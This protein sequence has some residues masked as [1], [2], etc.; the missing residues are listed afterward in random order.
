[1]FRAAREAARKEGDG[2]GK[3]QHDKA[4]VFPGGKVVWRLR[5]PGFERK[6]P[7]HH[8][9][10]PVG[11]GGT[12]HRVGGPGDAPFGVHVAGEGA[13]RHDND[14]GAIRGGL[15]D[16]A[17]Q[18]GAI[19]MGVSYAGMALDGRDPYRGGWR[20]FGAQGS[21]EA[22]SRKRQCPEAGLCHVRIIRQP[23]DPGRAVFTQRYLP[24]PVSHVAEKTPATLRRG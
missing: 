7:P 1:M 24:V 12:G 15:R 6:L 21:Q 16:E 22:G 5:I 14:A 9:R 23:R 4:N 11:P 3:R 13:F 18:Q 10:T 19:V 8:F 17:R 20:L 2:A